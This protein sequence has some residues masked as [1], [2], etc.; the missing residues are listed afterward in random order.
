MRPILL[1]G[2]TFILLAGHPSAALPQE[3]VPFRGLALPQ[4]LQPM[5]PVSCFSDRAATTEGW[6]PRIR[7]VRGR[8]RVGT[9]ST[10]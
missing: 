4:A 5:G 2:V 1:A 3:G 9:E 10:L 7:D 6:V 8:I